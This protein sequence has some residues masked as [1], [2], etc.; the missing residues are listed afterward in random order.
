MCADVLPRLVM[1]VVAA[2]QAPVV[3]M[4]RNPAGSQPSGHLVAG[5]GP[6]TEHTRHEPGGEIML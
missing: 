4:M 2:L 5:L 6:P 3:Q 1:P